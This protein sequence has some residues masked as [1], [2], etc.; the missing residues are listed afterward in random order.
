MTRTAALAQPSEAFPLDMLEDKTQGVFTTVISNRMR[1]FII[2]LQYYC[3][4]LRNGPSD[5]FCSGHLLSS[6]L[7]SAWKNILL[8]FLT[9]AIITFGFPIQ[10]A[11]ILCSALVWTKRPRR[12]RRLVL[13]QLLMLCMS[14]MYSLQQLIYLFFSS[15]QSCFLC[16]RNGQFLLSVF[17]SGSSSHSTTFAVWTKSTKSR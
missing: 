2:Q 9:K 10:I 12:S 13:Q 17:C 15:N 4:I 16:K 6:S 8:A 7:L 5:N 11:Q 1:I 14:S 3:I